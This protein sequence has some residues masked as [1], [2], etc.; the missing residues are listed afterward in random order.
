MFY[1]VI[2]TFSPFAFVGG[3]GDDLQGEED[4]KPGAA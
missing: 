1:H 3:V 4:M 2:A